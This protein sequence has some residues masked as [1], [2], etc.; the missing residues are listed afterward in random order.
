[1]SHSQEPIEPPFPGKYRAGDV[2]RHLP[3]GETWCLA[4]DEEQ[5]YVQPGGWPHY[6]ARPKEVRMIRKATDEQRLS[7]LRSWAS[8]KTSPEANND[9][10]CLIARRT[11]QEE[12]QRKNPVPKNPYEDFRWATMN[13]STVS[14]GMHCGAPLEVIIGQLAREKAKLIMDLIEA[15]SHIPRMIHVRPSSKK[16]DQGS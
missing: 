9:V 14:K 13:D 4:I 16:E 15:E 8:D 5:G 11:L 2:V 6:M 1:M 10:R 3:T 7:T 12:E